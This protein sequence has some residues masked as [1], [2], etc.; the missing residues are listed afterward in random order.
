M[1]AP[2][3]LTA[4]Y[5][6]NAGNVR[7]VDVGQKRLARRATT[8]THSQQMTTASTP[9]ETALAVLRHAEYAQLIGT[10]PPKTMTTTTTMHVTL[11][12]AWSDR[13]GPPSAAHRSSRLASHAESLTHPQAQ[14]V[15][16]AEFVPFR[17]RS[18]ASASH[19][20]IV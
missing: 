12:A 19:L 17:R 10:V 7:T 8:S 14:S 2:A 5:T 4:E 6:R 3:R 15:C 11:E 18:K 16:P 9:L 20:E 13:T 1:V